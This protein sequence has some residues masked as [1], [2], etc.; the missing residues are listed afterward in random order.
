MELARAKNRLESLNVSQLER[1]GGFG[2]RAD[3]LNYYNTMTGDPELINT[4]IER[5]LAVTVEDIQRV[6]SSVLSDSY[7]RLS[8]VPEQALKPS[9]TPID[10]SVMPQPATLRGFDPPVPRRMQLRNGL[11]IVFVKKQG[12]PLVAS[13]LL[14]RAGAITDP[15]DRPG[16]ANLAAAMLPEGTSTRTSRQIA[17]E[18]EFLGSHL[19]IDA[20]REYTFLAAETLTTHWAAAL[21]IMADVTRNASFPPEELERVRRERLTDLGRIADNPVAIATRASRGL[22]YGPQSRYGHP[23]SGTTQSVEKMTRD[24]LVGHFNSQY[25]PEDA[26]LIVVGDLSEDDVV[27]VAE[28]HFGGWTGQLAARNG[29]TDAEPP[30]ADGATIFLA[31]K[32]GAAQSIIRAGH[33]TIPRH[34][35]DYYA[36]NMLNYIFGGQ[37]SARLNAN[38]RQDKGYSYGYNS[39]IE[40][41]AGPSALIAGGGVET[42]VTKEAVAETLKE[43]EDIHGNKP[44]TV[45]E[46]DAARDGILRAIPSQFETQGQVL[47][48]LTR[49]VLFDLPDDY[50]SG[51]ADRIRGISLDDVHRVATERIDSSHLRI[52]VVGDRSVVEPGLRDLGLP[53]VGIDYEGHE[54]PEEGSA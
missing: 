17:E 39:S 8:V 33:L 18:M 54:L 9:S 47:Q 2:G 53:I 38:L 25:G 1:I 4:D 28:A 34:D 11:R 7:V 15:H 16:R 45:E 32:P 50:F 40:W 51:Y 30:T 10:R 52:L 20:S 29:D 5:Y 46:F 24:E 44:V 14:V 31:D 13:G 22:L 41:C 12:L 6:A 23:A 49:L 27:S 43:F 37:F 36:L 35:P 19:G 26:T 42:A 3:Q 48:Q 21:E